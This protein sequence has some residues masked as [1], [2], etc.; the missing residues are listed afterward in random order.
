ML[1][2]PAESSKQIVDF[3]R[4]YLLTTFQTTDDKY[5]SQLEAELRK[6][7]VI[8]SGPF[9]SVSDSYEK[10][11]TI[12]ELVESRLLCESML[13][14]GR[15]DPYA[16]RLYRH[17]VEATLKAVEKKNL[18]ITTG[19][20]SGKTECFLIPVVNELLKEQEAGT[21]GAGVRALIIY[22]MNALV[23]D[24]IRRLRELFSSYEGCSITYGKFTGETAE[25][26]TR[27]RNEFVEREGIEPPKN[28]LICREQMRKT[29]PNIL[30]TNYAMLEYL[31]LRPGD[32]AFFSEANADKWQTII[33]DEAH[34]YS[35]A[36]GIEVGTL[37]KR[38]KAML[39]RDDIQFILTSATL[40]DDKSNQKIVNFAQS[41]CSTRFE[42]S[43][44]I[45]SHTIAPSKPAKVE[46]LDFIIYKELAEKIRDNIAS[47]DVLDWLR[48]KGAVIFKDADANKSLEKTLFNMIL[49]DS[50]YY[51]FRALMLNQTK[52]LNQIASELRMDINDLTDFIAVASNAQV[53]GDKLFE[54][55]YHMFLRGIEGVYITLNPDR[56]LFVRKMETYKEDPFSNDCGYK[57]FAISFCHNCN[58]TFIVGQTEDGFLVQKSKFND[59]Y[60]PE[61]YLLEGDYDESEIDEA[62]ADNKYVVCAKCGA[63]THATSLDGL[64]CGHDKKYHNLLRKVKEKGDVLHSCPCCHIINTQRSIIRPYFLGN[65][66]ATAVI[67]T[68]LYNVLPD[69]QITKKRVVM[70]DDFFGGTE[71]M[72]IEE[73][74]ELVKQFLTFSDSRQAAA[75][76]ASYLETTYRSNLM[77]RVMTKI[78]EDH[79][80]QFN[81]GITLDHFVSLLEEQMEQLKIGASETRHKAAW[82]CAIKELTNYKAKNSLQN[83]G[84]L[85]FD[86]NINMPDN[87]NLGMNASEVTALFK[88]MALYFVKKAAIDLPIAVSKAESAEIFYNGV[89]FGFVKDHTTRKYI[90]SWL[91][92]AGKDNI[93]TLFIKRIKPDLSDEDVVRLLGSIW[94]QLNTRGVLSFD[95]TN[96]RY[97]LS[98]NAITVRTV[99]KLYKCNE[100]KMVTPF[101]LNGT[102]SNPKCNG[103]LTE[104]NFENALKHDHY[105]NIYRHLNMTDMIAREHTAQLGSQKAYAYQNEF[106][107]EHIN[108]LSC[109]TTFEMGVD[110]G[111]LETVFMRNMPPSPANYAQRAGR[112]GRSIKSAA[113]ALTYCQNSSHDLNYFKNPVDMI[114]GTITPP[115]FNVDNEKIVLRHIFASAF[116]FFWK[117]APELF[118]KNIGE[119]FDLNGMAELKSYLQSNPE[120]LKEYLRNIVSHELQVFYGVDTFAWVDRLFSEDADTPGVFVLA[121]KKYC[122]DIDELEKARK[123][124]IREQRGVAPGSREEK[125][126]TFRIYNIGASLNTIKEQRLIE[127]LSR[128]NL[129]PK[130]GFPVDTVELTSLGKGGEL[131]ELRLDR[132]LFSAISEYAP[133][134]EVVA[135]GK[136]ITSRYVRVLNGYSWPKYN[137]ATCSAC[138]TLNR[139]IWTEKLPQLCRQCGHELPKG[140]HQYIIPKFGFVVDN[141]EPVDVGTDKPERTYKGSISYIGDG[142]RIE[143]H[144]YSVCN[145]KVVV[146]TSKMDELAVLNTSNFYICNTCGYGRVIDDSKDLVKKEKHKKPDGYNCPCDT[147]TPYSIGHEFQTDV[148][149]LKFV[150]ENVINLNEAWTIL[151][152]LLEGLSKCLHIDRTELSGCLHWYRNESMGNMGNYGFVLFDN[153]PGGAGYVRQLR[154]VSTFISMLEAALSIVSKC[155][156]GGDTGDTAC[157]GC[158]CNYYNQKQHDI[159]QRRYA[160]NFLN[161]VKNGQDFF[162]GIQLEDE[163]VVPPAEDILTQTAYFNNDGQDQ[164]MMS[165]DEIWNYL[166]QDTEDEDQLELI[167]TIASKMQEGS[168]DKPYY[169]AS[170]TTVQDET[171]II[172]DLVWPASK[173]LLFLREN[174]E[175][176][177]AAQSTSWTSFCLDDDFNI[178]SFIQKIKI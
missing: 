93:R 118:K 12:A 114:K 150:S 73:R 134:S 3:Y 107:N 147:L 28:E 66:A 27:A 43:S 95:S 144:T 101:Y 172:A 175:S 99:E 109:S 76:F 113:Y 132:D 178:P 148:V 108:V 52:P 51:E 59:D 17:Q 90:E 40:G 1:F 69:S 153:T 146:G 38:V 152:A 92:A 53:S 64:S 14:L 42:E 67:A 105:H 46:K 177:E 137:Y 149:L 62:E 125:N 10:E 41:L 106:K 176:F 24:Q 128:N 18:I 7:G 82:I 8:S 160:I 20:G 16:R 117:K 166:S 162:F 85:Y 158:L 2:R 123:D 87:A 115:A 159:L 37:L 25:D 97:L 60:E 122:T 126:L 103:H 23:N 48:S 56:H 143:S 174:A 74:K 139:T 30:I 155:T 19:T 71:E 22:P 77:K 110:V 55:R 131:K 50:F 31:L 136:L 102:C 112:A 47:C 5:N 121:H 33:L 116:S 84:I 13:N 104:Y 163:D 57:V 96:N 129:I 89:S 78:C 161:S 9:V 75:F 61:V 65:E 154:N 164:S 170:I 171:K 168:Y 138:Q 98:T 120:D 81:R 124:C 156:C 169:S 145:K 91:P 35:G 165:Y 70:E 88:L 173:V 15:L 11:K 6:D 83:N 140:T 29:P 44:I 94:S 54:A 127:F 86:I 45:R 79:I 142:K 4:N 151:Y 167:Q 68:G 21:L 100:C 58:A 26:F 36:K 80:E 157:Y 130:Y 72:E 63:I 111:S 39:K 133:D 49:G 32:V 135:D 34:T 119:F 141:A